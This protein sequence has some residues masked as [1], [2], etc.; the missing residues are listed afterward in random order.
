MTLLRPRARCGIITS[1]LGHHFTD[2]TASTIGPIICTRT[3][4]AYASHEFFKISTLPTSR[5]GESPKEWL[6]RCAC[7]CP[8]CGGHN[9]EGCK[10]RVTAIPAYRS[11]DGVWI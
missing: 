3:S 7:W 4:Y 6:M 11:H 5:P 1:F 10:K 9:K 2:S 8:H